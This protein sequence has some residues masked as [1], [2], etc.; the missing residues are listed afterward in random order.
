LA[1]FFEENL[2]PALARGLSLSAFAGR[3]LGVVLWKKRASL[4]WLIPREKR[5]RGLRQPPRL[6]VLKYAR[7]LLSASHMR[8]LGRA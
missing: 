5:K 8:I 4:K 3:R 1:R 2:L 6:A 7:K